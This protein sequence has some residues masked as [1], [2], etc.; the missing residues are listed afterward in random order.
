MPNQFGALQSAIWKDADFRKLPLDAQ[1]AYEMLISQP[2]LSKA[3]VLTICLGRWAKY[4]EDMTEP[5][6]TAALKR[7]HEAR[8]IQADWDTYELLVRT[9]IKHDRRGGGDSY[10]Q[11]IQKDVEAIQSTT[12][13]LRAYAELEARFGAP[14]PALRLVHTLPRTPSLEDP[15]AEG[16]GE[17]VGEGVQD[18]PSEGH[19]CSSSCSCSGSKTRASEV[20]QFDEFWRAYPKKVD[21]AAARKAFARLVKAGADPATITAGAERYRAWAAALTGEDRRFVK[22]PERWLNAGCWDDEL[23]ARVRPAGRVEAVHQRNAQVVLDMMSEQPTTRG[24]G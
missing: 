24:I 14:D 11:G 23:E 12:L 1:W 6:L 4:A 16:V 21:K 5:R 17:G 20:D 3:G 18:P 2:D 22:G 9:F 19:S 10:R 13:Q 7:L 8:F 15:V